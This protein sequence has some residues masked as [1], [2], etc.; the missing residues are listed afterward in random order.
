MVLSDVERRVTKTVV[1]RFIGLKE[2]SPRKLLARRHRFSQFHRL[3]DTGIFRT[4]EDTAVTGEEVYLPRALAFYYC[5]DPDALRLAR[6]SVITVVHALQNLFDVEVDKKQF[7]P[8]D[9][10][11][12]ANKIF[13]SRPEPET[14]ELGLYLARDIGVLT[15]WSPAT[16]HVVPEVFQI[17]E[18]IV[19]IRDC[20]KVWDEF[21]ARSTTAYDDLPKDAVA[22]IDLSDKYQR[23]R[24]TDLGW[25]IIHPEIV[26]VTKSRFDSLHFADA[27]EAAFKLIN[28][29]IKEIVRDR[30]G[31]ECDG[32]ALMQR[33]FSKDKP[34]LKLADLSTMIGEDMQVGYQQI[35]SG[36]IRG[37]RNPKAHA[38]IQIDAIRSMH[39]IYLASLLMSKVDEALALEASTTD[40]TDEAG[41]KEKG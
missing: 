11:A 13:E 17:A 4:T 18:H 40:G 6:D 8:E 27:A 30:T 1:Q 15:L 39:F 10:A 16:A 23:L 29:R 31:V 35:F 37:I 5:D 24:A 20:N 32:V 26:R 38:N 3:R 9:L 21:I 28:E 12:Q 14:L 2:P 19:E 7:R 33:A 25:P 34:V 22:E 36:A 41:T